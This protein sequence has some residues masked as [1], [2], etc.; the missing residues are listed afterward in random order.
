MG[1]CCARNTPSSAA[2][3]KVFS[4][5]SSIGFE[6]IR[7]KDF[8]I[9]VHRLQTEEKI[10]LDN[11]NYICNELRIVRG[12]LVYDFFMMVYRV[13]KDYFFS[14]EII[15][16]AILFCAG[17][18]EEKAILL[19]LN[20]DTDSPG[21]LDSLEIKIMIREVL[22]VTYNVSLAFY[23]NKKDES[24]ESSMGNYRKEL[25]HMAPFMLSYFITLILEGN[26]KEISLQHFKVKFRKP[27]LSI[28][29]SPHDLRLYCKDIWGLISQNNKMVNDV[30]NIERNYNKK[31]TRSL[32]NKAAR[33]KRKRQE[34]KEKLLQQAE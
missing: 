1:C 29:V 11:Y 33:R 27:E 26:E 23:M 22:T 7:A 34:T 6:K 4:F 32:T 5:E 3:D 10:T 13:E 21:V 14:R 2:E 30:L 16:V 15:L 28:L 24:E 31:F 25:N 12:S 8:H 18:L 19:Y 17:E 20:Y 9:L